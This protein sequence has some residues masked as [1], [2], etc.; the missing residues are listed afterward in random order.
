MLV[1]SRRVG[2]TVVIDDNIRVTVVS[3]H[4]NH[5]RLSFSAPPDVR[6]MRSELLTGKCVLPEPE[7]CYAK[8]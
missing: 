4:G 6:I 1:L 2:E 7:L 8:R 5:V 3:V